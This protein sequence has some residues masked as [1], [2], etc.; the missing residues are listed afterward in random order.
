MPQLLDHGQADRI[1]GNPDPGGFP[2]GEHNF[3]D[4]L[5]PFENESVGPGQEAFHR[6]ISIVGNF[7]VEADVLQVGADEAKRATLFASFDLVD[8]L[9]APFVVKRTAKA[10]DCIRG[11]S[12]DSSFI[13]RPHHALDEPRL[14]VL[15]IDPY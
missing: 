4:Q 11:I 15:T 3:G 1:I 13:Q 14:R 6:F 2:S 5:G 7:A 9:D 10:I 8:A 12:N